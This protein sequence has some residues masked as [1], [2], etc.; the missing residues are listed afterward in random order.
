MWQRSFEAMGLKPAGVNGSYFQAIRFRNVFIIPQ[1]TSVNLSRHGT[2]E[3]LVYGEDYY[4]EGDPRQPVS[5]LSGQV[6]YVGHGITAPD[7]GID[8]YNGDAIYNGALD[9]ASGTACLI[10]IARAFTR[11][12]SPPRRSIIFLGPTAEEKGLL[13]S[14]YFA[15]YPTI[16]RSQIV[17]NI[18][19]D[20]QNLQFDFRDVQVLGAEDSTLGR[21]AT[22]AA[23]KMNL[24]VSPDLQPEQAFFRRSDQYSFVKRG[25]PALYLRRGG[26][27]VDPSIDGLK[28]VNEWLAT[29]YHSPSDD[30]NQPLNWEAGAKSARYSF[31]IGY[32]VAQDDAKPEWNKGDFFGRTF[33]G[34]HQQ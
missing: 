22:R 7:F 28:M 27:A 8:D 4:A 5:S 20:V 17:A 10:E 23:V 12:A 29:I 3:K 32:I 11:L 9:N 30:L 21:T 18:N 19:M 14:D 1:E 15:E 34:S 25:I 33:G 26:K 2:D 24:E 13:G 16:P 31:L 6:V